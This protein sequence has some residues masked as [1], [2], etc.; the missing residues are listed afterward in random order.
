MIDSIK[1]LFKRKREV[2]IETVQS[3]LIAV[4]VYSTDDWPVV[5]AFKTE[6]ADGTNLTFKFGLRNSD[7]EFVIQRMQ[8]LLSGVA[9]I[10]GIDFNG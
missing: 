4:N 6:E 7:A 3:E 8:Y 2:R 9:D 10:D 5:L 1:R